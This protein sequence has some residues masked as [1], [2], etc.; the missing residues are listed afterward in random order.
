LDDGTP[1]HNRT[2]PTNTSSSND[3][4][5]NIEDDDDAIVASVIRESLRTP[6]EFSTS[7]QPSSSIPKRNT[8]LPVIGLDESD[9]DDDDDDDYEA[10]VMNSILDESLRTYAQA[11]VE[12]DSLPNPSDQNLPSSKT[13]YFSLASSNVMM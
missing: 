12:D 1:I 13:I 3:N 4:W 8:T 7:S 2:V 9:D 5:E 10:A 11:A 6:A